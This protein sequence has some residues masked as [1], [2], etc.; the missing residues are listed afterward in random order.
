[1]GIPGAVGPKGPVGDQGAAGPK[2]PVGD[3]GAVG[4]KGPVGDQGVIGVKGLVGD[5]S[6]VVG[7]K[8][9]VGLVTLDGTWRTTDYNYLA[10]TFDQFGS[11][12]SG[13]STSGS[14][15]AQRVNLRIPVRVTGVCIY[16]N[17]AGSGLTA[18]QCFVGLYSATNRQLIA[19]SA[20]QSAAWL[21]AGGVNAPL[22]GG[23][24]DLPAGPYYIAHLGNGTTLPNQIRASS[25]YLASAMFLTTATA[26]A[27]AYST[28]ST[29]L[30]ASL[31]G[32]LTF[33]YAT[34]AALY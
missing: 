13:V 22:L 10:W 5:T 18:G 7:P 14:T 19:S 31:P 2:G 16:I 11:V 1:M 28:P 23:P 33:T 4:P 12:T 27:G 15:Y 21:T 29:T 25:N 8:G 6:N 30:P 32:T 34:W 26:R 20:D 3:Q 24:Y 9:P 17:V